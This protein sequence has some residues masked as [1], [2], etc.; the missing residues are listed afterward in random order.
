VRTL[1]SRNPPAIFEINENELPTTSHG[2]SDSTYKIWGNLSISFEI[3]DPN[4]LQKCRPRP[5]SPRARPKDPPSLMSL[6]ANTQST[7]TKEYVESR[8]Y[9]VIG[10]GNTDQLTAPR[11][12]FQ[13]AGTK[14]HQG[15]QG[16]RN[17]VNGTPSLRIFPR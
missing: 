10:R 16:I 11:C 3:Q 8:R 9:K 2:T 4:Y 17:K 7:S 13:E 14:S 1:N 15:D 5:R 12:Y 6:R